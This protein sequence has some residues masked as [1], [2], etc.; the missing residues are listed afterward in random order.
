MGCV[1]VH[2]KTHRSMSCLWSSGDMGVCVHSCACEG[3]SVPW[4]ACGVQGTWG[5]IRVLV[6]AHPCVCTCACE[7]NHM[8]AYVVIK[9][10]SSRVGSHSQSCGIQESDSCYQACTQGP[11]P[12]S[13]LAGP[14]SRFIPLKVTEGAE[15]IYSS[16]E[17]TCVWYTQVQSLTLKTNKQPP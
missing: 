16:G 1:H 3:T 17:N 2:V 5:G 14:A 11:Y 6:K 15:G 8:C 13:Q 10:I 12:L 7:G 4:H 9:R